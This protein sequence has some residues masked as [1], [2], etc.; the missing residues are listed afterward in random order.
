MNFGIKKDLLGE[1]VPI[2]NKEME[3]MDLLKREIMDLVTE[4][5]IKG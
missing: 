2:L 1:V 4:D 3:I 5:I